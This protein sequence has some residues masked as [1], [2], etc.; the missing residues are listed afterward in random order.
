MSNRGICDNGD[1]DGDKSCCNFVRLHY[2]VLQ[3]KT[4]AEDL[5]PVLFFVCFEI[6]IA[7]FFLYF[8]S[9][10]AVVRNPSPVKMVREDKATWKSNYFMRIIVSFWCGC[11]LVQV[12]NKLSTFLLKCLFYWT[13]PYALYLLWI[14]HY[15]STVT[16]TSVTVIP[17][18]PGV[19]NKWFLLAVL[20]HYQADRWW[21]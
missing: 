10:N 8:Q 3:L 17:S 11:S 7:S 6:V 1:D 4:F 15:R 9:L 2:F 20:L 13:C 18:P 19:A 12:V 21:E 16:C 5:L 14:F